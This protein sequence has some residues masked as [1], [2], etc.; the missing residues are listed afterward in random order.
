MT[1]S[2]YL[3][4]KNIDE[5]NFASKDPQTFSAWKELFDHINPA[6]FTEQKRFKIN[7]IRRKFL[8]NSEK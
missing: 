5:D 4:S 3:Q 7:Q 8:L 1:F 2:D 6:S